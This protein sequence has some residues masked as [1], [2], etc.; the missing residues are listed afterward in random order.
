M[1]PRRRPTP[2]KTEAGPRRKGPPLPPSAAP[3]GPPAVCP[4]RLWGSRCFSPWAGLRPDPVRRLRGL[5]VCRGPAREPVCPPTAGTEGGRGQALTRQKPRGKE[6]PARGLGCCPPA[7][8][9]GRPGAALGVTLSACPLSVDSRLR[10]CAQTRQRDLPWGQLRGSSLTRE[11]HSAEQRG[12]VL[13]FQGQKCPIM[14]LNRKKRVDGEPEGWEGVLAL[15]SP[16][17]TEAGADSFPGRPQVGG[18]QAWP[19]AVRSTE[20]AGLW[21]SDGEDRPLCPRKGAEE[22]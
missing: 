6:S 19:P 20:R 5:R 13:R 11:C 17:Y 1:G 8:R 4:A 15:T 18:V 7:T 9:P 12:R 14:S 21:A 3:A 16:C 10:L 2:P 22:L